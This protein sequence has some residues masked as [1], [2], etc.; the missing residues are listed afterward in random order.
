MIGKRT[1]LEERFNHYYE[2]MQ[3]DGVIACLGLLLQRSAQRYPDRDALIY[4]DRFISYK[5][6]YYCSCLLSNKLR[7]RGI[8]PRDRVLLFFENS[9]EFYIAYF[10]IVQIGAVVAPLNIFLSD[11]ELRHVI[12]DAQPAL[13]ISSNKLAE[14]VRGLQGVDLPDIMT[15]DDLDCDGPVPEEISPFEVTCL[16]SEEIAA[17]LYTSG[18]TG[19][20]K[21]VMLSSKNI[22]TNVAHVVSQLELGALGKE[23]VLCI[24]PLFHVLSQNACLW[25][26]FYVGITVIVVPRIDRRY[27]LAALN[28]KPTF[29]IGVPAVFG[30]LCLLKTAPL[31]SI[32]YFVSGGDALPDKIRAAFALLYRRKICSGYG[33]TET[34]PLVTAD[35]DD[36]TVPTSTVGRPCTYVD[37]VLKDDQGNEVAQGEIG[38]IWVRGDNVMLG[39]YNEP[40]MTKNVLRDGWLR[41]GDLA[42]FDQKGKVVIT[43]R[44]KDLI[45]NKGLNIYPQ[46]IENIILTHPNVFRV[47]VVGKKDDAVGEIPIAYV[48]LRQDE[49]DI[50]NKLKKFCINNLAPYKVPREFICSTKP[51][52]TTATGKVNKKEL[53]KLVN[54]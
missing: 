29:F 42:Y 7:E 23:R 41:T 47:G 54:K 36:E 20:P 32:R 13:I 17:L 35:L 28:H 4:N 51:L 24:L 14:K 5:E 8:K 1:S 16:G 9:L 12:I 37:V 44:A 3:T 52:A 22:M 21:G 25:S 15:E 46:E 31:G 11:R 10:G 27:I 30:L 34:S 2:D 53:R 33:L 39:Y 38:E 43:G 40:E 49:S 18:T 45:I 6:L 50:E 48:Q 26:S 19:L